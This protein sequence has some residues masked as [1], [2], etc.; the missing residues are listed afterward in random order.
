M[1]G[2]ICK[3]TEH[4]RDSRKMSGRKMRDSRG[5]SAIFLPAI[6]LLAEIGLACEPGSEAVS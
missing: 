2:H 6:L 3:T 4:E 1:S 5:L